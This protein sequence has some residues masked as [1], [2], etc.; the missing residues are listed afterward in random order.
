MLTNSKLHHAISLPSTND[1]CRKLAQAGEPEGTV[2]WADEQTAGRGRGDHGWASPPGG[3]YCSLLLRPQAL[4]SVQLLSVI[5][6]VAAVDA[7]VELSD[8][9]AYLKWPNDVLIGNKKVGGLLGEAVWQGQQPE[10]AVVGLG[11]NVN[12]AEFPAELAGR[13]TS[14]R[15]EAGRDFDIRQLL[16]LF[17]SYFDAEYRAGSLH[18]PRSELLQ[19]YRTRLNTLG[20]QVTIDT[21]RGIVSGRAADVDDS[22]HLLVETEQGLQVVASGTIIG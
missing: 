19:S 8:R 18:R 3:L 11:L 21:G 14:L 20:Q 6:G 4:A 16:E 9:N 13:A 12:Q 15:L 10:F 5:A 2:V 7:M 22:G 1:E 17:L